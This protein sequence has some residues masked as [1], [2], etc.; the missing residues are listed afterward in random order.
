MTS[1]LKF[2]LSFVVAA[3]SLIGF[4]SPT[5]ASSYLSNF[6]KNQYLSTKQT[7]NTTLSGHKSVKITIPKG[8]V[9]KSGS[10]G[11]TSKSHTPYISVD[12]NELS[13]PVRK[14]VI[15]STY[16]VTT[17]STISASKAKFKKV[18]A[19]TYQTYYK[20]PYTGEIGGLVWQGDKAFPLKQ[21]FKIE[22]CFRVTDDGYLE[23]FTGYDYWVHKMPQPRSYAKV[24]KFVQKGKASYLYTKT[25]VSGLTMAHVHKKGN[26]RYR[27]KVRKTTQHLATINPGQNKNY[28]DSV[29]ISIRYYVGGKK[30]YVPSQTIYP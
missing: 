26:N 27:L 9:F 12:V 6:S 1:K 29:R 2:C 14:A 5:H 24:Q 23:Y 10:L 4:A 8:T 28:D 18:H 11:K 16:N 3:V 7:I 21:Q 15:K 20:Q 19:P 17:T 22:N 30:F 25:K 13:W